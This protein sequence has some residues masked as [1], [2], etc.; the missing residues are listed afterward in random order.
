[1]LTWYSAVFA[2]RPKISAHKKT[3][4]NAD[5]YD[6]EL[7]EDEVIQSWLFYL[8]AVETMVWWFCKYIVFWKLVV[9]RNWR[10]GWKVRILYYK[11]I[12]HSLEYKYFSNF[13]FVFLFSLVIS[14]KIM[15]KS[16][17][18]NIKLTIPNQNWPSPD[19]TA[20][21]K[22]VLKYGQPLLLP[23]SSSTGPTL[24]P[25]VCSKTRTPRFHG[26]T[27]A[28]STTLSCIQWKDWCPAYASWS[29]TW[30]TTYAAR[31]PEA[32]CYCR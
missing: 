27:T 13:S 6:S 10:D 4:K 15:E 23:T 19:I 17:I 32:L 30:W 31:F 29:P 16:F 11:L 2:H 18:S 21:T 14:K 20:K 28:S 12:Q 7:T 1:M 22:E 5:V 26:S 8:F 3:E 25:A 24:A 9:F